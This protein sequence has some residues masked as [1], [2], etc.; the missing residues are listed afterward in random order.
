MLGPYKLYYTGTCKDTGMPSASMPPPSPKSKK[1]RT[2]KAPRPTAGGK[3]PR[4]TPTASAAAAPAQVRS[5]LVSAAA[6]SP[7]KVAAKGS[8]QPPKKAPKKTSTRSGGGS[9]GAGASAPEL[10]EVLE[11]VRGLQKSHQD[12]PVAKL[13]RQSHMELKAEIKRIS[14]DTRTRMQEMEELLGTLETNMADAVTAASSSSSGGRL[15]LPAEGPASMPALQKTVKKLQDFVLETRTSIEEQVKLAT[16]DILEELADSAESSGDTAG[17]GAEAAKALR[18]SR[19]DIEQA[20][21]TLVDTAG[22]MSRSLEDATKQLTDSAARLEG[23]A[24][25]HSKDKNKKR[26]RSDRSP[27]KSSSPSPP[28]GGGG[29]GT[30]GKDFKS[31]ARRERYPSS[32]R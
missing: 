27:S 18:G 3:S 7:S 31:K 12:E 30:G 4:F 24:G 6:A 32:R 11:I 5:A 17:A 21:A 10:R 26:K 8:K 2:S 25:R 14:V 16:S 29:G 19:K 1:S 9:G 23:A 20:T 13:M 22:Q 15:Q 28:R